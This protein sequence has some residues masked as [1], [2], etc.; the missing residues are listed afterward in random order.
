M[1]MGPSATLG[2]GLP[3]LRGSWVSRE[4][5][6]DY[7]QVYPTDLLWL[8]GGQAIGSTSSLGPRVLLGDPQQ[9]LMGHQYPSYIHG[10]F[11]EL[12]P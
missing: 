12:T 4:G 8:Q 2:S 9:C 7:W 10:S 5:A 11:L 6:Q 3:C 1:A